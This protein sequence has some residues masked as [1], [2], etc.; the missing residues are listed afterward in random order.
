VPQKS[1][2]S[3]HKLQ[4]LGVDFDNRNIVH[5]RCGQWDCDYCS[6]VNRKRWRAFLYAKLPSVSTVWSFVTITCDS[7]AHA[8]GVTLDYIIANFDK[9]SKRLKRA[10]GNY[11]YIRIYE[12]HKSGQFHA[13]LLVGYL[14]SDYMDKN[15]YKRV[16]NPK[17]RKS[18]K[19]YRGTAYQDLLNACAA[20]GFG[21]MCDFTPLQNVTDATKPLDV[22]VVT[23]YVTKYM[24]KNLSHLPKGTRRIQ[25]SRDIGGLPDTDG[26]GVYIKRHA[27]TVDDVITHGVLTDINY[28]IKTDSDVFGTHDHYPPLTFTGGKLGYDYDALDNLSTANPDCD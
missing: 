9:L 19:R 5:L 12:R 4:L 2:K 25:C 10:W 23:T 21:K 14:P 11:P 24:S 26:N 28:K 27:V 18:T 16:F 13:H 22:K 20:V 6:A 3:C 7:D 15:A 8:N 17:T 1:Q